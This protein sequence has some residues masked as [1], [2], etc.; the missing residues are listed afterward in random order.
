MSY[1]MSVKLHGQ[2]VCFHVIGLSD[3]RGPLWKISLERQRNLL[4]QTIAKL[5]QINLRNF[6]LSRLSQG[7]RNATILRF[8]KP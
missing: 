4:K 2:K 8:A 5:T 6:I 1:S 7:T 3:G